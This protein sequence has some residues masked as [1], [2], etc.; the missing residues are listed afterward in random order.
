MYSIWGMQVCG[1]FGQVFI[2]VI[3]RIIVNFNILYFGWICSLGDSSEANRRVGI[4]EIED[5][6]SADM[7]P[8]QNRLEFF[9]VLLFVVCWAARLN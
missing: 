3:V 9:W 7:S 4:V 6:L 2:T 1:S 8:S 5:C